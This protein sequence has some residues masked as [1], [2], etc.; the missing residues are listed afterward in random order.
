MLFLDFS[1]I[2]QNGDFFRKFIKG[3]KFAKS[4]FASISKIEDISYLR[5][6]AQNFDNRQITR[7]I[8]SDTMQSLDLSEMQKNNISLVINP[9]TLF[10]STGQQ[11]GFLGGALYTCLKITT[12]INIAKKLQQRHT[13]LHVIPIFW[14]EDN[15]H[16]AKEAAEVYVFDANHVPRLFHPDYSAYEN[17][18]VSEL[19][20]D[21]KIDK[22]IDEVIN[23]LP[24]SQN[25][26]QLADALH[27]IY[28]KGKRWTDAMLEFYQMLFKSEGLLF[29]SATAARKSG[30][31]ARLAEANFTTQKNFEQLFRVFS[32]NKDLLNCYGH[33][34]NIAF[35]YFNYCK[36]T[37]NKR[38]SVRTVS[39]ENSLYSI[40]HTL[41]TYEEIVSDIFQNPTFYSPKAILRPVFQEV[42]FPSAVCVLGPGEI[43]YFAMLKESYEFFGVDFPPVTNRAM[44]CFIP[45]RHIHFIEQNGFSLAHFFESANK[46][47]SFLS[48]LI[49]NDTS[50]EIFEQVK[51]EIQQSFSHLTS[52]LSE[53]DISLIRTL[54]SYSHKSSEFVDNLHKKYISALKKKNSDYIGKF[55]KIR[56]II[57][58]NERLQERQI[59]PINF[60][61]IY[62][63]ENFS[64]ILN[65]I[66]DNYVKG[67]IIYS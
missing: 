19:I 2:P 23:T 31:I 51:N 56:S 55:R 30:A 61:N 40:N 4:R 28:Y 7:R 65:E 45:E 24:F 52:I 57:L 50:D 54:E 5:R 32:Q 67:F 59:S 36:H 49:L 41:H 42:C 1:E 43:S 18:P 15:D 48:N 12:V 25:K 47:E 33:T 62:G 37:G 3:D 17:T 66:A 38:H 10:V 14:L 26:Q 64:K 9:N 35:D 53:T 44:A 20:F 22:T 27:S 29:A 39:L 6:K 60:I 8:I 63:F 13:K 34:V 11:V 58:P 21:E 46:F 16:D